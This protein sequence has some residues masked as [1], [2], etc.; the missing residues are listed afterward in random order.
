MESVI[1]NAEQLVSQPNDI[2]EYTPDRLVI[3]I[4]FSSL[5]VD[6]GVRAEERRECTCLIPS[7]EDFV[8]WIT[9]E[10]ANIGYLSGKY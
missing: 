10:A 2:P 8:R 5:G 7:D 1:P 9:E 6:M 4:W 3:E